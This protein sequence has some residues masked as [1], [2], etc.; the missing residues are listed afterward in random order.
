LH[1][2]S[3]VSIVDCVNAR[4]VEIYRWLGSVQSKE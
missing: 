4:K 2:Y 3:L 1:F